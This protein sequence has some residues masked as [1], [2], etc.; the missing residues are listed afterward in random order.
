MPA[1]GRFCKVSG[2]DD[3][4]SIRSRV[5][6]R[7]AARRRFPLEI[8]KTSESPLHQAFRRGLAP[9]AVVTLDYDWRVP[10]EVTS[11]ASPSKRVVPH[12]GLHRDPAQLGE[13]IDRSL[14]AETAVPRSLHAP[15]RHLRFV[16]NR[17]PVDVADP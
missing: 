14:A 9:D 15:E 16:V 1:T 2:A 7:V 12:A 4:G 10:I 17:G 3:R 11:S 13:L 8:V 5:N 6:P